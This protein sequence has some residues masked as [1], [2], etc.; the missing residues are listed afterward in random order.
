[1]YLIVSIILYL[2]GSFLC[3]FTNHR[4]RRAN[5]LI[6]TGVGCLIYA[7]F[8][9]SCAFSLKDN[10]K[11]RNFEITETQ[12]IYELVPIKAL[13]LSDEQSISTSENGVYKEVLYYIEHSVS[14]NYNFYY[15]TTQNGVDGFTS[16]LIIVESNDDIFITTA[17]EGTPTIIATTE[18]HEYP[19]S[20][21]ERIW[22]STNDI[23]SL[24]SVT[25]THYKIYVPE[26]SIIETF[27]P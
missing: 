9:I 16:G 27:R 14:D 21:F 3:I 11:Q 8:V 13:V 23:S 10:I 19:I 18:I 6:A 15:K 7:T 17:F 1:M 25:K 20:K 12:T 26:G 2:I 4:Q 5:V 22:L 24:Q